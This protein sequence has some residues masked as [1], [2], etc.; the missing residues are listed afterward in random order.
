MR[1]LHRASQRQAFVPCA[2]KLRKA[3]FFTCGGGGVARRNIGGASR[4]P[5]SEFQRG[6]FALKSIHRNK[7]GRASKEALPGEE[8]G[9]VG[10]MICQRFI[11]VQ[12][13]CR[14]QHPH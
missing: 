9:T 14:N 8:D 5:R 11:S 6:E 1:K 13:F 2:V 12:H 7:N 4:E 10:Y 3:D